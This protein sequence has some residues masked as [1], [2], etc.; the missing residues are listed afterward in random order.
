MPTLLKVPDYSSKSMQRRADRKARVL[1]L[2]CNIE[3]PRIA[4]D[5]RSQRIQLGKR[6][7]QTI[8]N[9]DAGEVH[10]LTADFCR[11]AELLLRICRVPQAP[12]GSKVDPKRQTLDIGPEHEVSPESQGFSQ[13]EMPIPSNPPAETA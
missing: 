9:G 6:L 5:L 12:A 10:T 8:P 13:P 3:P 2:I 1:Q 7:K 11:V 4:A